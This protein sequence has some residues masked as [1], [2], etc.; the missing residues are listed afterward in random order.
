MSYI[1]R[2]KINEETLESLRNLRGNWL[3]RRG[4]SRFAGVIG[5]TERS[6]VAGKKGLGILAANRWPGVTIVTWVNE[7]RYTDDYCI[8]RLPASLPPK[9]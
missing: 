7:H 8:P 9:I 1:R 5:G 2:E 4:P 3:S 6:L